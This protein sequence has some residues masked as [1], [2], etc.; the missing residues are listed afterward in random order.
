MVLLF[1]PNSLFK[2][3]IIELILKYN[4]APTSIC[5]TNWRKLKPVTH[6]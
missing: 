2:K 3:Y 6:L 4:Q 5:L 1:V